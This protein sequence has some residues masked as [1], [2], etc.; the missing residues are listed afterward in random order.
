MPAAAGNASPARCSATSDTVSPR[1]A[2]ASATA[3]PIPPPPTTTTSL[4]IKGGCGGATPTRAAT[5]LRRHESRILLQ[6][7]F[8]GALHHATS[9][10]DDRA[11]RPGG[12][13]PAEALFRP[14]RRTLCAGLLAAR[15]GDQSRHY[16]RHCIRHNPHRQ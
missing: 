9:H 7:P 4:F 6:T 11:V 13:V 14:V 15:P 10:S 1:S 2:V 12:P 16:R 8:F 5:K 3:R